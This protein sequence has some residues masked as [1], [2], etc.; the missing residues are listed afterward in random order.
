MRIAIICKIELDIICCV[1][2]ITN[3]MSSLRP[4]I[5][6]FI[7][8][9]SL[10]DNLEDAIKEF[11][12]VFYVK[13][14]ELD[15][16]C[17]CGMP[18]KNVYTY[19]NFNTGCWMCIGSACSNK[20]GIISPVIVGEYNFNPFENMGNGCGVEITK[21]Y[22]DK[23]VYNYYENVLRKTSV[24]ITLIDTLIQLKKWVENNDMI[25]FKPL[26][27][28][29]QAKI[30]KINDD[31]V[32]QAEEQEEER[33]ERERRRIH[34]YERKEQSREEI[35]ENNLKMLMG[36]PSLIFLEDIQIVNGVAIRTK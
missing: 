4:K 8:D 24:L 34:Q 6:K 29:Y 3:N 18:L 16:K 9:N 26:L 7:L 10:S 33:K 21:E 35:Y 19:A 32:K 12:Y 11:T 1:N 14:N 23:I 28:T 13:H 20:L 22:Y 31:E 5:K 27:H 36:N 17:V 15:V 25:I 30:W 2:N